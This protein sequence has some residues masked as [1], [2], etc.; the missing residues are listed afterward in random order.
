MS[1]DSVPDM[2]LRAAVLSDF[3][4]F[5]TFLPFLSWPLNYKEGSRSTRPGQKELDEPTRAGVF[6]GTSALTSE[7]T[8]DSLTPENLSVPI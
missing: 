6:Y 2:V 4:L 5:S 1:Y 8:L 3:P 7:G